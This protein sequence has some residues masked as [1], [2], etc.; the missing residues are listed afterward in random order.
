M[1]V[2]NKAKVNK[3]AKKTKSFK[4]SYK[5]SLKRRKAQS[6]KV[7]GKSS[8]STKA[9]S[10]KKT[11]EL[12]FEE[13]R[14]EVQ[15]VFRKIQA[16]RKINNSAP[17]D[18]FGAQQQYRKNVPENERAFQVMVGVLLSVQSRDEITDKVK[19]QKF[20]KRLHFQKEE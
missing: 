3:R 13:R 6:G 12:E 11:I 19:N 16:W 14:E 10:K 4:E 20:S 18:K 1:E 2:R 9:G 15:K 5:A 7:S 17:V 8:K